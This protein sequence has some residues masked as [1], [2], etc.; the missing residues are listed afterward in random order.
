[1][2]KLIVCPFDTLYGEKKKKRVTKCW[3]GIK[4]S[5]INISLWYQMVFHFQ[6]VHKIRKKKLKCFA[7]NKNVGWPG[8]IFSH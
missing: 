7:Q 1:M 8:L 4:K 2:I 6:R 5:L 3:L